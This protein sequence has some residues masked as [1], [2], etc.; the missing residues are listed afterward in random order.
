MTWR[1][2]RE[3]D[4]PECLAVNPAGMGHEF[5][6]R[7][8]AV[9]AWR[10]LLKLPSCSSVVV[11]SNRPI[12]G[13][14]MIGFG[15]SAFVSPA[16]ASAEIADPK[17]GLNARII[18]RIDAGHSVVLTEAELRHANTFGG[19]HLVVLYASWL[20]NLLAQE[21]IEE[22]KMHFAASFLELHAGYRLIQILTEATDTVDIEH[23]YS[24]GVHRLVSDFKEYHELHPGEFWNR[25]RCLFILDR[26]S[27]L[28][29]TAS[30][31]TILFHYKEPTLHLRKED[32][33]LLSAALRG[34]TDEELSEAL[35]LQLSTVKKRWAAVFERVAKTRPELLPELEPDSDRH[36]RGRQKRH[37]LLAYL[38]Q[39]P[40]ELRPVSQLSRTKV[41]ETGPAARV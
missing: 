36:T 10:T 13:H 27:A 30:I 23:G 11:E 2:A 1:L 22:I 17:P 9:L 41:N 7:Q 14:R 15:A 4:L 39:H 34:M 28:S 38:R 33:Q 31:A 16:F 24:T 12:A 29:V 40:E 3:D 18:S 20:R 26:E 21:Q 5:V 25:D 8:R 19:L 37:H 6:G 32:E 35:N